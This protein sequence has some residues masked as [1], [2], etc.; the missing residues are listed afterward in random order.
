MKESIE[1]VVD[2]LRKEANE[3]TYEKIEQE[4][5]CL[6]NAMRMIDFMLNQRHT[7]FVD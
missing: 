6:L 7:E 1:T 3:S 5:Q 2:W 4:I